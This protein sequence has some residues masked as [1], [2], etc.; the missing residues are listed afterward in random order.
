MLYWFVLWFWGVDVVVDWRVWGVW[1]YGVMFI[2]GLV[3]C[4]VSGVG[5]FF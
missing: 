1:V 4:L 2:E 3:F 5:L